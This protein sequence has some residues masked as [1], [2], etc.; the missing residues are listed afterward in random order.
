MLK[1][2]DK[3]RMLR[4]VGF[5]HNSTYLEKGKIY[6]VDAIDENDDEMPYHV[7]GHGNSRWVC[8]GQVKPVAES[9]KFKGGQVYRVD[10]EGFEKGNIRKHGKAK[11][12]SNPAS[13]VKEVR[14]HAK[15]GEYI[16]IVYP[17][18]AVGYKKGDILHVTGDNGVLAD[19]VDVCILDKEYVVLEGYKPSKKHVFTESEIAKAKKIVLNAL[20][21]IDSNSEGSVIF[22]TSEDNP[23]ITNAF[24]IK[25]NKSTVRASEGKNVTLLAENVLAASA[26]CSPTDEPNEWIGKCVA[27]CRV[28]H[29][30]IPDFIM[31]D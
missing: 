21:E 22:G 20:S 26:K 6:T 28:L 4:T 10:E 11:A 1:K 13:S 27:L 5:S 3:V 14:R 29:K 7:T 23:N 31:G 8:K 2:G 18:E 30:P 16:K 25:R 9:E 17:C 19:G 15:V 12:E 24:F